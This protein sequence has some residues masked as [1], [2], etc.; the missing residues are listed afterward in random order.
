MS[1]PVKIKLTVSADNLYNTISSGQM[2]K[3][4]IDANCWMSDDNNG[5]SPNGK[6]EDFTSQVY[7]DKDVIWNGAVKFPKGADKGYDIGINSVVY[8]SSSTDPSDVDFFDDTTIAGKPA[9][10]NA[11]VTAKVKNNS[12]LVGKHDVYRI[13]F[14]IYPPDSKNPVHGPYPIDPKLRGNP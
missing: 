10:K 3:S 5:S 11:T 14:S 1:K 13:N 12:G 8:E 7:L 9:G 6:I 4:T 2:P